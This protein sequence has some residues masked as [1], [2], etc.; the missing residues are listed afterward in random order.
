MNLKEGQIFTRVG[1]M[2]KIVLITESCV[3][4]KTVGNPACMNAGRPPKSGVIWKRSFL[5]WLKNNAPLPG[6]KIKKTQLTI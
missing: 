5:L 3:L 6:T 1:V 2:R 4:V